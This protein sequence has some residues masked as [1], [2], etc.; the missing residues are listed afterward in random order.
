MNDELLYSANEP[1][2]SQ[3]KSCERKIDKSA[4]QHPDYSSSPKGGLEGCFTSGI[5]LYDGAVECREANVAGALS[6]CIGAPM[7]LY[8][9]LCSKKVNDSHIE[10]IKSCF[11]LKGDAPVLTTRCS[12]SIS[13]KKPV[14]YPSRYPADHR[15]DKKRPHPGKGKKGSRRGG[16]R[17]ATAG[18]GSNNDAEDGS[19]STSGDGSNYGDDDD[20]DTDI[21]W[22]DPDEQFSPVLQ[23]SKTHSLKDSTES[24]VLIPTHGVG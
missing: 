22:P 3:L 24:A 5:M 20:D 11:Q 21:Q 12:P 14:N 7:G 17:R 2:L 8:D 19:G 13:T 18:D 10:G 16:T 23:V 9:C 4:Q 1:P 15:N 6:Y